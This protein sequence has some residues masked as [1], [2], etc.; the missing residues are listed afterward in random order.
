[1]YIVK[2]YIVYIVYIVYILNVYC[3][4]DWRIK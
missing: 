4:D 3:E 1:M 2:M